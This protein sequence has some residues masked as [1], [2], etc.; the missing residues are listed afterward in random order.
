MR[1]RVLVLFFCA[2]CQT[3]GREE[4]LPGSRPEKLSDWGL[5]MRRG[6]GLDLAEGVL[7]FAVNAALFSD[8]AAKQRFVRLPKGEVMDYSDTETWGFPL[9]TVLGKTFAFGE[10]LIETRLLVRETDGFSVHVYRWNDDQ[11]EAQRLV[12]GAELPLSWVDEDGV[13]HQQSYRIP[14]VNQCKTCH[15]GAEAVNALGPRT[16][17]LDR[18]FDYAAG[19]RNQIDYLA[20]EGLFSS[21]PAAGHTR[22]RLVDPYGDEGD[23]EHRARAYLDANC[24]HCHRP[25]GDAA[26]SGLWLTFEIQ[27]QRRLGVCKIPIAAGRGAGGREF[28]VVPGRPDESILV[29]RMEA[30]EADIRMPELGRSVVDARGVALMRAW[31]AQMPEESCD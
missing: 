15:A 19:R 1:R 10:Q 13:L 14:N 7:P 11:K 27:D 6:T 30:T 23:V 5:V 17:Q 31:I 22:Q 3:E 9:G 25:A 28:D 29:Y 16:R 8:Y 21:P 26:S 18:D 12:V 24:G 4:L 2:A 20:A